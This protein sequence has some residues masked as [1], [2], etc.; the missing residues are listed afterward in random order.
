M[1]PA[2]YGAERDRLLAA[3]NGGGRRWERQVSSERAPGSWGST[4]QR[5]P[6]AVERAEAAAVAVVTEAEVAAAAIGA[7]EPLEETPAPADAVPI[8]AV[9]ESHAP[10]VTVV[11][12]PY[13]ESQ[14]HDI[15]R[16]IQAVIRDRPG[17][18]RVALSVRGAG[19]SLRLTE[20]VQWDEHLADALASAA[21][22][23][24][25]VELRS[26]PEERLA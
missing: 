1:G 14:F 2:A 17:Q 21:G 15:V 24:V 26:G 16:S 10:V 8:Q 9:P 19:K 20:S 7:P 4:P 5:E 18:V 12:D 25:G 22:V 11:L 13:P 6:I 23:P 3:R